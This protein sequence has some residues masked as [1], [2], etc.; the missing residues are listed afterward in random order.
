[1]PAR[2]APKPVVGPARPVERAVTAAPVLAA[3]TG[4][5]WLAGMICT[6]VER[7]M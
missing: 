4:L 1:M 5:A 3:P 6:P 7:P 2:R